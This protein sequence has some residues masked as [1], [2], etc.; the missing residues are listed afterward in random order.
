[1][2]IKILLFIS[3]IYTNLFTS[4]IEKKTDFYLNTRAIQL[5]NKSK[6]ITRIGVQ[7][8][9]TFNKNI[10]LNTD[11]RTIIGFNNIKNKTHKYFYIEFKKLS[12]K[13]PISHKKNI[14]T[15]IGRTI[16]RDL[17]TWWYDNEL[18][19]I[20]IYKNETLLSW[21][22]SV[23]GRVNDNRINIGDQRVGLED[24]LYFIF[25]MDYHY[26][27]KKHIE[28]FAIYE[29]NKKENKNQLGWFGFRTYGNY[30]TNLNY[31]ID[32]GKIFTSDTYLNNT[33]QLINGYAL[34]LGS[35]YK[36]DKFSLGLDLAYGSGGTNN[37][38]Y[39]Q[40]KTSNNKTSI[41]GNTRY[42]Y[43]GEIVDPQLSNIQ[44]Y[45]I[46]AGS[47]LS[48]NTSIETAYH[49]YRQNEASIYLSNSRLQ[50]SPNGKN[51]D[52]GH[53]IDIIFGQNH[54]NKSGLQLVLSSFLGG[55]AFKKNIKKEIYRAHI[56]YKLYW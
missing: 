21:D 8:Q 33:K 39:L 11:I 30:R 54:N 37:N 3:L 31:W 47:F 40:P 17:R 28:F 1:M 53:G 12:L 38:R 45:S 7:N 48:Q 43:Y 56:D 18:D 35:I 25:H 55:N 23:G 51:R 52:I 6:I 2:K 27:F 29:K 44:I 20:K 13:F 34:D 24:S 50:I 14:N 22:A 49:Y 9:Q 10:I 46:F 36:S 5:N 19:V 41:L 15:K 26:Y 42:R 4:D 16:F 32:V